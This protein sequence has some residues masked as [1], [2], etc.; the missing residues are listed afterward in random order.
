[1]VSV[2]RI[3]A[4]WVCIMS[5]SACEQAAETPQSIAGLRMTIW[6]EGEEYFVTLTDKVGHYILS[7]TTNWKNESLYKNKYYRGLLL[8]AREQSTYRWE[9]DVNFQ[10]LD[11]LFP[12][13]VGE[14]AFL[15]GTFIEYPEDKPY[16]YR[17]EIKILEK[18]P[19]MLPSGSFITYKIELIQYYET[20]HGFKDWRQIVYYSPDVGFNLKGSFVE[21]GEQKHWRISQIQETDP[22]A[23]LPQA[24][25]RP[26]SGTVMI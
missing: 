15:E 19:L 2:F 7:E 20:K 12:L 1:V 14:T 6:L 9:L 4:L 16:G 3:F 10:P 18:K 13:T 26:R 8:A 5:T 25:P 17:A 24:R 21:N 22:N 11:D 23:P